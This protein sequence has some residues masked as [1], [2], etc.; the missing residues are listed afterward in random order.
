MISVT[1][2]SSAPL[3]EQYCSFGSQFVK[4]QCSLC[5][6]RH[7]SRSAF[8]PP[9]ARPVKIVT[10]SACAA[11]RVTRLEGA[12]WTSVSHEHWFSLWR[13][14]LCLLTSG[15]H[16]YWIARVPSDRNWPAPI[17]GGSAAADRPAAA[18]VVPN[19]FEQARLSHGFSHQ[20]AEALGH[21]FGL[22]LTQ[23]P[24]IVTARPDCQQLFTPNACC[25]GEPT[26]TRGAGTVADGCDARCCFW[27]TPIRTRV[28]RYL[29]WSPLCHG[30]H[31]RHSA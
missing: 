21:S 8:T 2:G 10:D 25:W 30:T 4:G 3:W 23:A 13:E 20:D 6:A 16:A 31:R 22:P 17:A 5:G 15:K 14:L 7:P 11:A 19:A 24:L 18:T 29:F 27:A 12:R 9:G 28:Y 26:G 1:R